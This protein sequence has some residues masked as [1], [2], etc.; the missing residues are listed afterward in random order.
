M[1]K[2]GTLYKTE[3]ECPRESSFDD[4]LEDPALPHGPTPS[5]NFRNVFGRLVRDR[6]F[7][8]WTFSLTIWQESKCSL[9]VCYDAVR[10]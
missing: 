1:T 10:D 8:M 3:T 7:A 4:F 6:T 5:A 9:K 2:I